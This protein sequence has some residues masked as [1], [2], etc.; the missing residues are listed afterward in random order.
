L[1]VV[2]AMAVGIIVFAMSWSHPSCYFVEGP[3]TAD[4]LTGRIRYCPPSQVDPVAGVLAAL[5]AISWASSWCG[6]GGPFDSLFPAPAPRRVRRNSFAGRVGG[7]PRDGWSYESE[8]HLLVRLKV[9][10]LGEEWVAE[11]PVAAG[12]SGAEGRR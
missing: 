1:L 12:R 5:V 4:N 10:G 8:L 6:V 9:H 7:S 2:V 3:A 11:L